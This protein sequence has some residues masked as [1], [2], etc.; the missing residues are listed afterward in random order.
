MV[1]IGGQRIM[2]RG[3]AAVGPVVEKIVSPA[4]A[5][6]AVGTLIDAQDDATFTRKFP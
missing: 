5:G 6:E 3:R 4:R 1:K 2:D